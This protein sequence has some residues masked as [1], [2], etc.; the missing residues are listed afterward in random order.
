MD[1]VG[2]I[3]ELVAMTDAAAPKPERPK[4]DKK[5]RWF[6]HTKKGR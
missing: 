1:R 5:A 2:A 4:T 6:C 3:E